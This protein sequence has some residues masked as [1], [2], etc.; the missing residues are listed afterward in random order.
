MGRTSED[1]EAAGIDPAFFNA[2]ENLPS[3]TRR[4]NHF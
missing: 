1:R 4:A 3:R 2:F